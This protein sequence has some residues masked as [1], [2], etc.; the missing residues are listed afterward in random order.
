MRTSRLVN[1]TVISVIL[2]AFAGCQNKG[3]SGKY[4]SEKNPKDYLELKSDGTFYIQEG[5]MG[6][7]GKY[8]IEG[9]QITLKMDM[10]FASRG[11]IQGKTI[12]DKDGD[13]WT[14]QTDNNK[15]PVGAGKK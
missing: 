13:R 3:P 7:T 15:D 8:E 14:E 11:R 2:M 1:L 4:I 5:G 6:V 10:G 12:I 9:D